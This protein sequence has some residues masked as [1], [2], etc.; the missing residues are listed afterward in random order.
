M[1]STGQGF[2]VITVTPA[3][4]TVYTVTGTA[5]QNG[6]SCTGTNTVMVSVNANPTVTASS[7]RTAMC[8]GESS[9]LNPN[10]ATSY[11]WSTPSGPQTVSNLTISPVTDQTYTLTGV[12]ANGCV[13]KGTFLM[14]VATCV[15]INH[16]SAANQ[17]LIIY[18][19][20]SRGEFTISSDQAMSVQIS[21][22]LGQLI[23]TISITDTQKE[24]KI[25][26][27]SSGVYFI[28]G[29]NSNGSVKQKLIITE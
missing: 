8:I 10:G 13:G 23:K 15:G 4:N 5:S 28:T 11:T 17:Q 18:P 12:D 26:H 1:W 25:N 21:N 27:L 2:A 3:L 14:K 20:P 19:N 29:E 9:V 6:L 16:Y 22:E 24:V 7:S